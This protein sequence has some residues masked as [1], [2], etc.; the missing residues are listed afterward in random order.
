MIY[1]VDIESEAIIPGQLS[2]A[3]NLRQTGDT[4]PNQVSTGLLGRIQRQILDKQRSGSYQ[5]HLALQHIDELRQLVN[6]RGAQKSTNRGEPLLIVVQLA[7]GTRLP[8]RPEL[9][10]HK[11][12]TAPTGPG[13]P[14]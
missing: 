12:A 2:S 11:R 14:E 5:A 4:R 3:A 1:V 8:H 9:V 7:A 6:A 13:L 10:D